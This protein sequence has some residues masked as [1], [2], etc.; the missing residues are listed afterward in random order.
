MA[1]RRS[2]KLTVNALASQMREQLD[3]LRAELWDKVADVNQRVDS[4]EDSIPT[5]SSAFYDD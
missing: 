5:P 2:K 1:S 4:V 3:D